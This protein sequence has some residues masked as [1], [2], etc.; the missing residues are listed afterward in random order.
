M[1]AIIATLAGP[2]VVAWLLAAL[3]SCSTPTTECHKCTI[4]GK[5]YQIVQ[6]KHGQVYGVPIQ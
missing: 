6:G 4:N 5:T 1:K 3:V 2:T